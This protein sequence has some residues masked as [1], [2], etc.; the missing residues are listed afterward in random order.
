M[1]SKLQLSR[2]GTPAVSPV[3]N[4]CFLTVLTTNDVLAGPRLA[5][6][7]RLEAATLCRSP[8]RGSC[9]LKGRSGV[10]HLRA[11][12]ALECGAPLRSPRCAGLGGLTPPF[13]LNMLGRQM[14]HR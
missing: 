8:L 3:G 2:V 6:G 14:L 7:E 4:H 9:A 5:G 10:G 11:A 1:G 12:P 13:S